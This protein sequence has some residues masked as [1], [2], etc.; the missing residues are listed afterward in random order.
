MPN[1]TIL[2]LR[3][4]DAYK[5]HNAGD[6]SIQ[7]AKPIKVSAGDNILVSKIFIDTKAETDDKI[8]IEED[9][10][11]IL[12]NLVYVNNWTMIGRTKLNPAR[13]NN[14]GKDYYLCSKIPPDHPDFSNINHIKQIRFFQDPKA[15]SK[16][17]TRWGQKEHEQV[18]FIYNDAFG[19]T[20]HYLMTIPST[21][22]T[23]EGYVDVD[24]SFLIS[25]EIV[26]KQSTALTQN[27]H[28][29]NWAF[30][31]AVGFNIQVFDGNF[32]DAILKPTS[33]AHSITIPQGD[34]EAQE[35]C[36]IMNDSMTRNRT[37]KFFTET[38]L[39]NSPYLKATNDFQG[40]NDNF[41]VSTDGEEVLSI[42]NGYLVG[43]SQIQINYDPEISLFYWEIM[44]EP[45]YTSNGIVT[46]IIQDV[47]QGTSNNFYVNSRAGGIVWT[48]LGARKK[49][50]GQDVRDYD[51]WNAKLG[52]D[53]DSL[54]LTANNGETAIKRTNGTLAYNFLKLEMLDGINSTN[55]FD[56]I[57]N[58]VDKKSYWTLPAKTGTSFPA[59]TSSLFASCY[60][61]VRKLEQDTLESGYFLVDIK[62]GFTTD[63]VGQKNTTKN[64]SGIV[65]RYYSMG[66]YTTGGGDAGV[67]YT[68]K[69]VSEYLTEFTI[70]IL[71]PNKQLAI[72][73]N[74]NTIFL[75]IVNNQEEIEAEQLAQKKK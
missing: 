23:G 49:S 57:D 56:S 10:V 62:G 37:T 19:T 44:H 14:D 27:P 42:A 59:S 65:S 40:A 35:L 16:G 69:G 18:S 70:R 28:D 6:Y 54:T 13:T 34:Y 75:E 17:F 47:G 7:L 67:V 43:S 38:Q 11:L 60:A 64:I 12:N 36:K 58:I 1:T 74:D 22:T 73:G 71:K 50:S 15:E 31:N 51:F 5:S 41:Y 39:I 9:I 3:E 46:Q 72:V 52:F 29:T 66:A 30:D 61:Q 26:A 24:C 48:Y 20:Q 33:F 21:S 55:S 63:M 4:Q 2:E 32:Q 68:H 53:L 45:T 25:G 8:H